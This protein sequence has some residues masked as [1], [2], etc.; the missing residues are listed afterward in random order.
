MTPAS[1]AAALS[2]RSLRKTLRVKVVDAFGRGSIDELPIP[3][4]NGRANAGDAIHASPSTRTRTHGASSKNQ[5]LIVD[6][7]GREI[8]EDVPK[9]SFEED[10]S[11]LHDNPPI[12]R[13]EALAQT[14]RTLREWAGRLN[15]EDSPPDNLA[16]NPSHSKELEER[17]RA[18]RHSRNQLARTLRIESVKERERDLMYKYTKCAENRSRL[19]PTISGENGPFHRDL[20]WFGVLL[21]IVFVLVMWRFAHAQARHLF[22][23][24]YY[25]P[26]YPKL[27]SRIGERAWEMWAERPNAETWP[28]T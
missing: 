5:I 10:S 3:I 11:A 18:A 9:P 1:H 23:T 15:E 28:P 12:C 21:Q 2:S 16:L 6:A 4:A 20:V 24:V 25:D 26:L 27:N 14:R 22:C 8:Q 17:S 7:M 19:L 13:T